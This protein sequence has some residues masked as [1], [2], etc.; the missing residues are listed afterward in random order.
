MEEI[1]K[2]Q[3]ATLSSLEVAEMLDME[4]WKL[5]RKLHG[6]DKNGKHINGILEILANNDFVV[7]DYFIKD[8]YKDV[9]GKENVC[10]Q[11]TKMGCEFL[12][13]KCT[14]ERGVIFTAKYVKRFN[15][16][17]SL[18]KPKLPQTFAEAL[19]LAAELEE[20]KEKLKQENEFLI[21]ERK[22]DAVKVDFFDAVAGTKDA[23]D[24]GKV[25]KILN[26]DNVGRNKMFDILRC[27][28]ILM[29]DNTPYQK[30]IDGNFFRVI[31][32]SYMANGEKR[33]T[34]KTLAYQKGVF[35]IKRTLC[36]LGY[37]MVANGQNEKYMR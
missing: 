29:N 11:I 7:S 2:N 17:E 15:D 3:N 34:T 26:F 4:H 23:I 18:L 31:E 8:S 32:Q 9:S 14:G 13:N 19:R 24:M 12:G 6:E 25:A 28:G 35:L 37:H 36:K 16:M 27:E 33:M 21:E 30:Y 10:Y 5:L 1:I 20:Q 22:K